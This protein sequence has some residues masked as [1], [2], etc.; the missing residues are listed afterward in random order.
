MKDC[1]I[2]EKAKDGDVGERAKDSY[3]S[4]NIWFTTGKNEYLC[5]K[6][7]KIRLREYQF[8]FLIFINNKSLLTEVNELSIDKFLCDFSLF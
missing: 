4:N 1:D 7:Q 2:H 5:S 8:S 6:Q 3:L